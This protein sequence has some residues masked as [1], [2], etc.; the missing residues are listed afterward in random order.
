MTV[1]PQVRPGPVGRAL[2]VAGAVW[3]TAAVTWRTERIPPLAR[4]EQ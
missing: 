4:S 3:G 1:E 2:Y